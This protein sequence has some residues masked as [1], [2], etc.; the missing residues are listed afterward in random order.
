[1]KFLI[2]IFLALILYHLTTDKDIFYYF[3]LDIE[4]LGTATICLMECFFKYNK[5]TLEKMYSSTEIYM[6]CSQ[7]TKKMIKLALSNSYRFQKVLKR[8]FNFLRLFVL[9]FTLIFLGRPVQNL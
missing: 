4:Q 8:K 5:C 2:L 7:F 9:N 1:M 3:F 6:F